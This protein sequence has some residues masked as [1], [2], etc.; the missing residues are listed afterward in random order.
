MCKTQPQKKKGFDS[1]L[2]ST[3]PAV[4]IRDYWWGYGGSESPV[5]WAQG[6]L[7]GQRLDEVIFATTSTMKLYFP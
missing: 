5:S 4:C 6:N 7:M 2:Q 3:G 1:D